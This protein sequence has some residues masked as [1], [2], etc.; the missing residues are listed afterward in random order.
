MT[1]A[2]PDQLPRWSLADIHESLT[3][4]SFNEALERVGAEA[5]RLVALF[6]EHDIR[7]IEPRPV[8]PADGVTADA[9]VDAWNSF[10]EEFQEV[11]AMVYATVTTDSRDELAQSLASRLDT[12]EAK[13]GP[14]LARLADW[15]HAL[16]VDELAGVSDRVAEHR[17]PLTR[18]DQRAAHQMSEIE[19]GLY[20]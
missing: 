16:G 20:A 19:E 2:R 1:S 17:G 13:V 9:V 8:T 10:N 5:T 7:A 11:G 15:V 18:L 4:R 6:D 14:L 3:A 12:Q